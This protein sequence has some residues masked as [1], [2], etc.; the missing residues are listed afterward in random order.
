MKGIQEQQDCKLSKWV[1]LK[2]CPFF[3]F[4]QV[5]YIFVRV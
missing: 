2:K 1:S 5:K 4:Y 3:M